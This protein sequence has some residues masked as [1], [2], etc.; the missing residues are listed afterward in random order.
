MADSI[1]LKSA[2][3]ERRLNEVRRGLFRRR[4]LRAFLVFGVGSLALT[5][6]CVAWMHVRGDQPRDW[7][8]GVFAFLILEVAMGASL[9]VNARRRNP[10]PRQIAL[11]VDE[12]HPELENLILSATEAPRSREPDVSAWMIDRILADPRLQ[13]DRLSLGSLLPRGTG[14]KF[15]AAATAMLAVWF[16]ILAAG[17]PLWSPKFEVRGLLDPVARRSLVVEPGNARVRPGQNQLIVAKVNQSGPEAVLRWR[18]GGGQWREAAMTPGKS[19]E[20]HHHSLRRIED[21]IQY[22]VEWNGLRS[23]RYELTVWEPPQVETVDLTYHYPAYL[24]MSSRTVPGGGN[25]AGVEGTRVEIRLAA[26]KPVETAALLFESG[27]KLTLDREGDLAWTGSLKLETDD[28]YQIELRD[29]DGETNPV[30][31]R[32]RV[33]VKPDLPPKI[34]VRHPRGDSDA[35][36]LDEVPFEFEVEDDFGLADYGLQY[37]IGDTEPRRVSL[38]KTGAGVHAVATHALALEEMN[39]E[40]GDL[41]TWSAWAEDRRPDREPFEGVGDLYFM[42]VRP[43]AQRFVEAPSQQ[44]AGMG[45]GGNGQQLTEL[46]KE[47]L[48]ATWNLRSRVRQLGQ[49]EYD[50]NRATILEAELRILHQVEELKQNAST[51]EAGELLRKLGSA[52][53]SAVQSLEQ[54]RG[55]DA[56]RKLTEAERHERTAYELL[57]SGAAEEIQVSQVQSMNASQRRNLPTGLDELELDRNRN[58]YE[59]ENRTQPEDPEADEALDRLRELAARQA[60]INEEIAKLI[61]ELSQARTKEEMEEIQRRLERLKEEI[62]QNLEQLDDLEQQL[63]DTQLSSQERREAIERIDEARRQNAN[64]LETLQDPMGE[65]GKEAPRLQEA[66][67]AGRRALDALQTLERDLENRSSQSVEQ[68]L[69]ELSRRFHAFTGQTRELVDRLEELQAE[70]EGP[71]LRAPQHD[72][73]D[74][75]QLLERAEELNDEFVSMMESAG[76]LAE[77]AGQSQPLASR[78]LGDWLRETSGAGIAEDLESTRESLDYALW[79]AA[80]EAGAHAV[81]KLAAAGDR[82]QSILEAIVRGEQDANR[83]ALDRLRDLMN[84]A[85]LPTDPASTGT[86]A[87]S[88]GERADT[89]AQASAAPD[90]QEDTS[91]G[92]RRPGEASSEASAEGAPAGVGTDEHETRRR[93]AG[94]RTPGDFEIAWNTEEDRLGD[95]ETREGLPAG[96]PTDEASGRAGAPSGEDRDFEDGERPGN[97]VPASDEDGSGMRTGEGEP[98]ES[99]EGGGWETLGRRGREE[100]KEGGPGMSDDVSGSVRGDSGARGQRRPAGTGQTGTGETGTAAAPGLS[101]LSEL[102]DWNVDPVDLFSED[103]RDWIDQLRSAQTVLGD[104]DAV[105]KELDRIALEMERLRRESR[106]TGH[107]PRFDLFLERVAMPLEAAAQELALRLQ[108][109]ADDG[110]LLLPEKEEVPAQYQTLVAD[111]FESLSAGAEPVR[112]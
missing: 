72:A 39:L 23:A 35:T 97:D 85:G 77:D 28:A 29:N 57:L 90:R 79:D 104:G 3:L 102:R 37:Q 88:A 99:G 62:R 96:Q 80:E 13:V 68:R 6:L 78:E 66:R 83:I 73:G 17:F 86:A 109:A 41:V 7:L 9:F 75:T 14:W 44:G 91:D 42:K 51:P 40:T 63:Q 76:S 56:V 87:D 15:A 92:D 82:L 94:S 19:P 93:G 46:Q 89:K 110:D 8:L 4:C 84:A 55:R 81:S 112:P 32:Y 5:A 74:R 59:E 21:S 101:Q 33:T 52:L 38:R 48:I 11:Y 103:Y 53:T 69:D 30:T 24:E 26:N 27:R 71:G 34:M 61:S 107:P 95:G 12:H 10:T 16:V 47:V 67:S 25:I 54:A 20:I 58:F 2:E 36:L 108:R 45:G 70:S 100:P 18:P 1:R 22:E 106:R 60:L 50:A 43:F 31:R 105:S 49:R 64:S 111:Y 65:T 98:G